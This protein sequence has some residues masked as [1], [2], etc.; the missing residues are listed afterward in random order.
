MTLRSTLKQIIKRQVSLCPLLD[1]AQARHPPVYADFFSA[2]KGFAMHIGH[3]HH[4]GDHGHTHESMDSPGDFACASRHAKIVS[5]NMAALENL[6]RKLDNQIDLL[7]VESRGGNL[8]AHFSKGLAD[9]AIHVI[10]VSRVDKM[11]RKGAS[12]IMRSDLLAINKIDIADMLRSDIEA[13]R[14]DADRLRNGDP[15]V[16]TIA[17]TGHHLGVVIDHIL[18]ARKAAPRA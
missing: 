15:H 6:M 8:A 18:K 7:F 3:H 1:I 11:P 10:D 16:F 14:R 9:Y 2:L 12:G 5:L 13:M 4:H 17:K